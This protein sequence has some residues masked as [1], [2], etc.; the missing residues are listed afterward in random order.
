M[1]TTSIKIK[2]KTKIKLNQ[3]KY[4]LGIKSLDEVIQRLLL[5]EV[6][7]KMKNKITNWLWNLRFLRFIRKNEHSLKQRGIGFY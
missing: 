3:L 6:K 4:K 5:K 2:E 7:T 1:E